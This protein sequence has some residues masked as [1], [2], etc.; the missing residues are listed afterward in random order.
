[1]KTELNVCQVASGNAKSKLQ[2]DSYL[3]N[4]KVKI[5]KMLLTSLVFHHQHIA[6]LLDT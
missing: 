5:Q 6:T 2:H 1:M 3:L 4:E